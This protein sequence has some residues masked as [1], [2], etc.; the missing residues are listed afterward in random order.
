M[1]NKLTKL[2]AGWLCVGAIGGLSAGCILPEEEGC[3]MSLCG[4]SADTTMTFDA[5]IQDASMM[6]L[7]GIELLCLGE[8]T[9]IAVS[10]ATG[11]IAF[12]IETTESPGC[13]FGRCNNMT[14][15]DPTGKRLDLQGTYF[16]FNGQTLAMP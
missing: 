13:G 15:H 1:M 14:L 2:V 11:A 4:C 3:G 7:A 10:D 16:S 9:P 5:T 12:S 6:P 8:D